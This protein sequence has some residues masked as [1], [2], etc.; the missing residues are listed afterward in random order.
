[1]DPPQVPLFPSLGASSI[2]RCS[3]P[4]GR[5]RRS[6]L[7]P[8]HW[9]LDSVL[10]SLPV[11]YR[12]SPCTFLQLDFPA[13]NIRRR[14]TPTDLTKTEQSSGEVNTGALGV[15]SIYQPKGLVRTGM[16]DRSSSLWESAADEGG[17]PVAFWPR[18]TCPLTPE[19][20]WGGPAQT[21]CSF[22]DWGPTFQGLEVEK[23]TPTHFQLRECRPA[24]V[25]AHSECYP[26]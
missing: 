3:I 20:G 17:S 2:Q 16:G 22:W 14:R 15:N 4:G 18:V 8:A 24:G 7:T 10:P 9:A 13:Q 12:A 6:S 19:P 23:E 25:Q 21:S 26:L 11:G 5:V 1:M